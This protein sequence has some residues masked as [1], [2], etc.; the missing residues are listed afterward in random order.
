LAIQLSSEGDQQLL[1]AV[2]LT[3]V[4]EPASLILLGLGG[5][6]MIRRR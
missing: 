5:L 6:V 2:S 4:P 1:D 3:Y